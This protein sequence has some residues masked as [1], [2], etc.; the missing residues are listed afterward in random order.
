[1]GR[2]ITTPLVNETAYHTFVDGFR[3]KNI[4]DDIKASELKKD[5]SENDQSYYVYEDT[6]SKKPVYTNH[7]WYGMISEAHPEDTVPP[8]VYRY[9]VHNVVG[10][11]FWTL[12]SDRWSVIVDMDT[13]MCYI[14]CIVAYTIG[15]IVVFLMPRYQ[16][17][18]INQVPDF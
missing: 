5:L 8:G 9:S 1:L 10:W 11:Q 13:V 14:E 17:I 7:K 6:I 4:V 16:D 18:S 15:L 2:V 3:T 12:V